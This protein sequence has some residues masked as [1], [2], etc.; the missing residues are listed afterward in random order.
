MSSVY[1]YVVIGGGIAGMYFCHEVRKR[2]KNAKIIIIEASDRL[3]GRILTKYALDELDQMPKKDPIPYNAGAGV[4]SISHTLLLDLVNELNLGDKLH[5]LTGKKQFIGYIES[6][7]LNFSSVQYAPLETSKI[8]EDLLTLI[9]KD[10]R[11]RTEKIVFNELLSS[12][13]VLIMEKY[14][15]KDVMEEYVNRYMYN[16]ILYLCNAVDALRYLRED[17]YNNKMF[18]LSGGMEQ[19]IHKLKEKLIEDEIEIL[20]KSLVEY[21]HRTDEHRTDEHCSDKDRT[22]E[23]RTYI[24]VGITD[25]TIFKCNHVILACPKENIRKLWI[26]GID[27][28]KQHIL[29]QLLDS[30]NHSPLIRVYCVFPKSRDGSIWFSDIH[31]FTTNP[32]IKYFIPIDAERGFV[33]ISY[34][35]MT[36]A[37]IIWS[38]Y[39]R[40]ELKDYLVDYYRKLFP[41]KDIPCID[42]MYICYFESGVHYWAP[43][44]LGNKY[45]KKIQ[46]PIE[47]MNLHII[48]EAFS[49]KQTWSEGAIESA[50]DVV[51]M[52]YG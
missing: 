45:Y 16:D 39:K 22:D 48:G 51:N 29:S 27:P 24:D 30:V 2:D 43:D 44:H 25:G 46:K 10:V 32:P 31:T 42:K 23:H 33:M 36:N 50:M 37:Q 5:Q 19:I 26:N 18:S 4:I 35:D 38:K 17:I 28:T 15:G 8:I 20:T 40:G 11:D 52:I 7:P 3:G 1:D 13:L 9:K 21:V 6:D 49:M 12:N 47:G 14:L 34:T 41:Q